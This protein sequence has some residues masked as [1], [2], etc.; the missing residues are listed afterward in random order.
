M[1]KNNVTKQQIQDARKADLYDYLMRHHSDA[2]IKEGHSIR[3]RDNHSMSIRAGYSGYM[4]FSTGEHGNAVDFLIKHMGYTFVR[5]V[6]ALAGDD[7]QREDFVNTIVSTTA[8]SR[9]D[10]QKTKEI[11]LPT[12]LDGQY[13]Q[14]Y[15]YLTGRGIP[16]DVI[17]MLIGYKLLYQDKVHNNAVFVN[18]RK[19]YAEIRGTYM[20]GKPY[21]SVIRPRKEEFWSFPSGE[22]PQ[23]AYICEAAI[24]AISLCVIHRYAGVDIAAH[25][26]SI[27]GVTNQA[28]IDNIV[29]KVP[30]AKLAVD[31]DP[32][33]DACA[34]RNN[35]LERILPIGKDWNEDLQQR[36]E[37]YICKKI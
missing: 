29:A 28:A 7:S 4:D 35:K 8:S 22:H 24:D 31:N 9:T 2:L 12:P 37:R 21:H 1:G 5:A 25:Y 34:S 17:D 16:S 15:T 27:G 13:T 6:Q 33:G 3:L 19:N 18:I 10:V 30:T 32:A 36:L 23:M 26:C 20:H 14:L 11:V